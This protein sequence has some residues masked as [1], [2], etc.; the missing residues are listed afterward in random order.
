MNGQ[1]MMWVMAAVAVAAGLVIVGGYLLR[2]RRSEALHAQFG[3]EYD[4]TVRQIGDVSRAEAT[5]AARAQRVERLAIRPLTPADQRRFN[6]T[7]QRVQEQFVD[8][9]TQAI[10]DA[11]RLIDEIMNARGYPVGDF[12]QR[13][14]DVSV[15]HPAVVMNYRAAREIAQAQERGQATTEDL[16]QAMIHYR[17]LCR[18]LLDVS[19]PVPNATATNIRELVRGPR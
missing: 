16:R 19:E 5:L 18:D 17:A 7:W 6:D 3:P 2:R 13:V 15:H 8:D 1:Q 4:R 9:P 11:N 10:R 14:D 12:E